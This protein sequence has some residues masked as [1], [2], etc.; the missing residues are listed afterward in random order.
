MFKLGE[1]VLN[2]AL[3]QNTDVIIN[4]E[5]KM[6]FSANGNL[7]MIT[8]NASYQ[9]DVICGN[10]IQAGTC[11]LDNASIG[12]SGYD[13]KHLML[14]H[15]RLNDNGYAYGNTANSLNPNY[16]IAHFFVA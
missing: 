5:T 2:S 16:A 7:G 12:R 15:D 11:R 1:S 9:S 3:T 6:S 8:A 4:D 13:K 10:N 14:M